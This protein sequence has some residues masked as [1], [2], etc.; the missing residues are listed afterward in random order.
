MSFANKMGGVADRLLN[1]YDERTVK[2]KLLRAG[3][4]VWDDTEGEYITSTPTEHDL[5]GV[6]SPYNQAMINGTTIQANDVRFVST[7]AEEPKQE[8]KVVLDGQQYSIISVK[9]YAYT[10]KDLTIAYEI[11]LRK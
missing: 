2:V 9:P 4:K 8:D 11:Q 10:G 6:A 1:K 3:S 5:I 7:R